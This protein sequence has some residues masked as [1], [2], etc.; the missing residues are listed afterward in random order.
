LGGRRPAEEET[1]IGYISRVVAWI[2]EGLLD[3]AVC[4]VANDLPVLL[5]G[6]SGVGK[7]MLARRIH[8]LSGRGR[9]PWRVVNCGGLVDRLLLQLIFGG[10]LHPG[11]LEDAQGGTFLMTD[12]G[13]ASLAV[14]REVLA[15][16]EDG[17]FRHVRL[18][19]GQ[20]P[21]RRS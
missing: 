19:G 16:A 9:Q 15:R 3:L 20:Q 11:L 4:A 8:D 21:G 12:V 6:E 14:Q 7:E 17:A 18:M 2:P 1:A 13:L 5:L 10:H